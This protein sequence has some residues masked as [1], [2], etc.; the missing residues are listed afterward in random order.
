MT[1][2]YVNSH[3]L[4]TMSNTTLASIT[5]LIGLGVTLKTTIRIKRL[6]N[7]IVQEISIV[8]IILIYFKKTPKSLDKLVLIQKKIK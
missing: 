5:I 6:V 3:L 8:R 7:Q 2:K 4:I 1:M